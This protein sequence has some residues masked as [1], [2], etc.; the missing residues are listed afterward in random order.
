MEV[1]LSSEIKPDRNE[2]ARGMADPRGR[3]FWSNR[4]S[5]TRILAELAKVRYIL[6]RQYDESS[7]EV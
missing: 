5:S 2:L 6:D 4:P 7:M 1:E 3:P